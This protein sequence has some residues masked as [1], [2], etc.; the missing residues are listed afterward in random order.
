[1][2]QPSIKEAITILKSQGFSRFQ[3]PPNHNLPYDLI[4]WKGNKKCHIEV[5]TR[6]SPLAKLILVPTHKIETLK[7]LPNGF[8][9]LMRGK[10]WK[11]LEAINI[12]TNPDVVLKSF[13]FGINSLNGARGEYHKCLRCGHE[14]RSRQ[15]RKP[16]MCSN[17]GSPYWNKERRLPCRELAENPDRPGIQKKR[18][19]LEWE[20]TKPTS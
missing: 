15:K 12:V 7:K 4:A 8:L 14:W 11:L 6:A 2:K 18:R 3:E 16:I 10:D 9:L 13:S 1:M 17:C 5:R 20:R 19:W